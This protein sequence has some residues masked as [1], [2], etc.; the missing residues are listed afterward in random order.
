M[1]LDD[2]FELNSCSMPRTLLL[3]QHVSAALVEQLYDAMYGHST[4]TCCGLKSKQASTGSA[5][6]V[7]CRSRGFTC[8]CLL[9]QT[10]SSCTEHIGNTLFVCS[11]LSEPSGSDAAD[12]LMEDIDDDSDVELVAEAEPTPAGELVLSCPWQCECT[13]NRSKHCAASA[14]DNMTQQTW[15][16]SENES[17]VLTS[18][19][20]ALY[21]R[22]ACTSSSL[23]KHPS[24][25]STSHSIQSVLAD[26]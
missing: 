14:W 10:D 13:F 8:I 3:C 17:C 24:Q 4:C 11:D 5:V 7:F 12:E 26:S 16:L 25:Q 21:G 20:I 15:H 1:R 6:P 19:Y 2:L 18:M 9:A 23:R 22:S